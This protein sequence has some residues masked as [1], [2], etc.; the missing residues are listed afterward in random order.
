M[1][2]QQEA[3]YQQPQVK[4][5]NDY[6]SLG[7]AQKQQADLLRWQMD[8]RD[9]IREIE[10]NLL[11]IEFDIVEQRYVQ[12]R[13]PMMNRE[14]VNTIISLTKLELDRTKIL[15]DFTGEMIDKFAE[16]YELH[17][18]RL[19]HLK[20]KQWELDPNLIKV[21]RGMLGRAVF[22]SYRRAYLG[23]E[24]AFLRDTESRSEIVT[25]SD[26]FTKKGLFSKLG[27]MFSGK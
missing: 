20:Y 4:G 11:G 12:A 2:P 15:S 13:K 6:M 16:E 27:G 5:R 21:L 19:L 17:M 8:P 1:D 24:R 25:Q 7:Y 18:T 26:P 23:G 3:Q 10:A 9:I 14:G 22:A